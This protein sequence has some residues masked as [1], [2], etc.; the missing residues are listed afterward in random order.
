MVLLKTFFVMVLI[1]PYLHIHGS[2]LLQWPTAEDQRQF[3]IGT[4]SDE[5]DGH[6]PRGVIKSFALPF[7]PILSCVECFVKPDPIINSTFSR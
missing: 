7:Q 6:F 1:K 2:P 4:V 5:H 3:S